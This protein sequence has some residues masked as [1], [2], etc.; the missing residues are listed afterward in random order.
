LFR[1][2]SIS[3]RLAT[4]FAT[5]FIAGWVLFGVAMWF[6]LEQTLTAGRYQ[7]LSRRA[8]RLCDLLRKTESQS[9]EEGAR[10]FQDFATATGD[11]LTEVFS[12]DGSRV[13]Q[14]PSAEAAAFPWPE[15]G[16][17]EQFVRTEYSGQQYRTLARPFVLGSRRLYICLAAP[18]AGNQTLL[19][20]FSR[21]LFAAMPVLLLASAAGGYFVSRN[22]L[23]PVDQI[24][25]SA[26]S[27]S[28]SNLS[29]R[30]PVAN[31]GDELQRLAETC[32][33][34]L[35][36]LES[37][38]KQIRRFTA[39]ASHELRGP[40]TFTRTVAEVALRNPQIDSKSKQAF[41]DIVEECSKAGKLLENMLTLARADADRSSSVFE[42]I[43]MVEVVGDVCSKIRPIVEARKSTLEVCLSYERPIE[44]LGDYDSLSRLLWILLDNSVKY[45]PAP[46][47]IT[48]ALIADDRQ[49]TVAVKDTGMGISKA[50]L[51]KI[52]E[53]FY[54]A[55]RSRGEVEGNGLGLSIAKWVA[56]IHNA[57]LSVTS[58]ENVGTEFK[59]EFHVYSNRMAPGKSV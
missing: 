50:D 26:R 7:T 49:V 21:G 31:T 12:S 23:R 24:T 9:S 5:F 58:E 1:H 43:D 37:A 42:P 13:Y 18:L 46:G 51:P 10:K 39:D 6:D 34:M 16:T 36:R 2:V 47:T 40:I 52:F 20:R 14:S 59:V 57:S 28:G 56:D 4:W 29:G 48:V 44:V 32:N 25:T 38:V 27:I 53:R 19:Q 41:G 55:D 17:T 22:A 45:T 8:D 30:L 3:L 54:R 33:D 35:A 11:G 15:V